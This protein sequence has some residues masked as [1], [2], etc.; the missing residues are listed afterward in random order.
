MA[1]RRLISWDTHGPERRTGH[2]YSHIRSCQEPWSIVKRH[3]PGPGFEQEHCSPSL[4][5]PPIQRGDRK[6]LCQKVSDR[7]GA[8]SVEQFLV[9]PGRPSVVGAAV[10][11]TAKG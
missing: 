3:R 6:G 11:P 10:S 9:P 8:V 1:E 4:V 5:V 2:R 7:G